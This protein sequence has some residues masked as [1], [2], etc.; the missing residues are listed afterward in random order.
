MVKKRVW[1]VLF[2]EAN[3][4]FSLE[5]RALGGS[6]RFLRGQVRGLDSD[7]AFML[8]YYSNGK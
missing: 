4:I 7:Y 2:G 3:H 8:Y 1:G 6:Q 5:S